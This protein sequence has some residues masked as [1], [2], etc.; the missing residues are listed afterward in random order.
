M[1]KIVI[2]EDDESI[3][4]LVI[5]AI[6]SAGFEAQGFENGGVFLDA[7]VYAA[8]KKTE[9]PKLIL[10]DIMM[11]EYDGL[12]V[13]KALRSA[14][15]YKNI[16]VIMLT[17]K[18]GEANIAKALDM[19]ADDYVTK[20][21]GVVELISRVKAVL[22]RSVDDSDITGEKQYTISC[23]SITVNNL[24]RVVLSEGAEVQLTYKEYELLHFLIT[25]KG[26][27]LSRDMILA[28]VWGHE[29]EGETRTVDMHIKTLRQK[30]GACGELIKTVRNVGYKIEET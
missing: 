6:E 21:F 4:E 19:G 27:V 25:K 20:P 2:V 12:F 13:L 10:L 3:R 18:S 5:Y 28:T 1:S 7:M 29:Y 14:P 22:R 9:L 8:L 16:P 24:K 26:V 30:L 23:G 11:P 15:N 17:A